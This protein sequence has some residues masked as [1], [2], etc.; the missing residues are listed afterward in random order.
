MSHLELQQQDPATI[1]AFARSRKEA[2]GRVRGAAIEE[3]Y[4]ALGTRR[5]V[6]FNQPMSCHQP[7]LSL[8]KLIK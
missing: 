7:L 3:Y 6:V 8:I 4:N 2:E 5:V 1:P